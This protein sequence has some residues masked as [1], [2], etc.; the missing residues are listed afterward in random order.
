MKKIRIAF[1]GLF[2]ILLAIPVVTFNR[3]KEVIS[4]DRQPKA[5]GKS[6]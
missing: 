1:I 4:G 6:L 5:D 2:F 3:E